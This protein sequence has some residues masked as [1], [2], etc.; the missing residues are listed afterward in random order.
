VDAITLFEEDTPR[1]LIATLLPD[2]LVKGGDYELAGVVGRDDVEAAG[3][4]VQII[5]FRPGYSTT[6]L[7]ERIRG[8][9]G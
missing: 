2:V 9:A 1:E 4:R 6:A 7:I 3:G 8:G 5:P